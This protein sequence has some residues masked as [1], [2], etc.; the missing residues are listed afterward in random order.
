MS[1]G[2]RA[3]DFHLFPVPDFSPIGKD[4][5][6]SGQTF[7]PTVGGFN[8]G[9]APGDYTVTYTATDAAGNA[10]T[11]TRLV[12]VM[13]RTFQSY[14]GMNS[15]DLSVGVGATFGTIDT[16]GYVQTGLFGNKTE[17][18][19]MIGAVRIDVG[20][21]NLAWAAKDDG[22]VFKQIDGH[23]WSPAPNPYFTKDI[24]VGPGGTMK[25]VDDQGMVHSFAVGGVL[26]QD[27]ATGFFVR[28]IAVGAGGN[29]W[30]AN[31]EGIILYQTNGLAPEGGGFQHL[32][33]NGPRARDLALAPDGSLWIISWDGLSIHQFK[34]DGT[35]WQP[36]YYL[37]GVEAE[38][39]TVDGNGNPWFVAAGSGALHSW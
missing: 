8:V 17:V 19:G 39:I 7:I 4:G 20:P 34:H 32:D 27:D 12:T 26:W 5:E 24:G 36:E 30:V 38:S 37:N 1:L 3:I 31:H 25:L 18:D 28:R 15:H 2:V 29:A 22:T 9:T 10:A 6:Y 13:P 14:G 16:R 33:V 11:A 21:D 35:G 23:S